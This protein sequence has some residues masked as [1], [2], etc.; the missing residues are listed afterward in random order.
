MEKIENRIKNQI[1]YVDC[2]DSYDAKVKIECTYN[3]RDIKVY[4]GNPAQAIE[5]YLYMT[6]WTSFHNVTIY[7][8]GSPEQGTDDCWG[9][10]PTWIKFN[11]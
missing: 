7:R 8:P 6:N 9:G 3:N 10:W 2:D 1:N 4:Y 5:D 11:N